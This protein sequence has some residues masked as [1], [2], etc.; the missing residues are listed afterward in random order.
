M[1]EGGIVHYTITPQQQLHNYDNNYMYTIPN[2]RRHR[3]SFR[4]RRRT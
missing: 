1:P 3:A 2:R 4:R